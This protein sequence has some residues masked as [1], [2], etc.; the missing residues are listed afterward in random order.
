MLGV[1]A[2]EIS[3]KSDIFEISTYD[4]GKKKP[5]SPIVFGK[6]LRSKIR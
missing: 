6:S 1:I 2:M 3:R 5:T 4:C